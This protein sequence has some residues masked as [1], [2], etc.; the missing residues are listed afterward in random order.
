MCHGSDLGLRSFCVVFNDALNN[1]FFLRD[2]PFLCSYLKNPY[3]VRIQ[4]CVNLK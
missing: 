1:V 3:N 2:G 4:C